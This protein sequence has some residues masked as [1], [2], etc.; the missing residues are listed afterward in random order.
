VNFAERVGTLFPSQPETQ[1]A[2][3]FPISVVTI[4]S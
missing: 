3:P 2:G 1:S 4:I